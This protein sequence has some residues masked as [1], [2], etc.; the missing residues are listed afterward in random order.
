MIHVPLGRSMCPLF[1]SSSPNVFRYMEIVSWHLLILEENFTSAISYV[2]LYPKIIDIILYFLEFVT[3]YLLGFCCKF[4]G[5]CHAQNLLAKLFHVI[6][7]NIY[8][9]YF[10]FCNQ[11]YQAPWKKSSQFMVSN[12]VAKFWFFCIYYSLFGFTFCGTTL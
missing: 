4:W 11:W 9:L 6:F 3:L 1:F 7:A 2:E 5:R 8:I 10:F 12:F